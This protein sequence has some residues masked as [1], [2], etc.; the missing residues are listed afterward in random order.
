MGPEIAF[1]MAT[2]SYWDTFPC[3]SGVKNASVTNYPEQAERLS[4]P[5]SGRACSLAFGAWHLQEGNRL[6]PNQARIHTGL[7]H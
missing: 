4:A 2:V 3:V 7:L 5:P 1:G 6:W